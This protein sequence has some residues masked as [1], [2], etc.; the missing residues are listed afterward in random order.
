MVA[1]L[2][3]FYFT[4]GS[5]NGL[6]FDRSL[7]ACTGR[8]RRSRR[9]VIYFFSNLKSFCLFFSLFSSKVASVACCLCR[10][11]GLPGEWLRM[12]RGH[13]LPFSRDLR[14]WVKARGN[15]RVEAFRGWFKERF[16]NVTILRS[17]SSRSR[18]RAHE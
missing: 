2:F 14:L 9:M 10:C 8:C 6:E 18:A 1:V 12:I 13:L 15:R 3:F 11:G 5:V 4:S 7:L 17:S 16:R